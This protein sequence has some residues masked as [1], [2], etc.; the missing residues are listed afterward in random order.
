MSSE[1]NRAAH[2]AKQVDP[3]RTV[4]AIVSLGG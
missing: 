3:V 2:G 1:S 4:V